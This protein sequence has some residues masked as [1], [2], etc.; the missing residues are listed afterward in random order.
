MRIRSR[1]TLAVFSSTVTTEIFSPRPNAKSSADSMA[2]VTGTSTSSRTARTPGSIAQSIT[3]AS[4]PSCCAFLAS[5]SSE[6]PISASSTPPSSESGPSERQI[7]STLTPDLA[8]RRRSSICDSK[9]GFDALGMIILI[10][11]THSPLVSGALRIRIQSMS[12][13]R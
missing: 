2:L 13:S 12:L 6:G 9:K 4:Y 11:N 1:M 5:E 3:I 7:T 10:F 8:A